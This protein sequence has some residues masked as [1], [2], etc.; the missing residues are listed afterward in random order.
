VAIR[1]ITPPQEK[2]LNEIRLKLL[3]LYAILAAAE[4]EESKGLFFSMLHWNFT[5]LREIEKER[6]VLN[7]EERLEYDKKKIEDSLPS[8]I[9]GIVRLMYLHYDEYM[10]KPGLKRSTLNIVMFYEDSR[11]EKVAEDEEG[12]MK[13][14]KTLPMVKKKTIQALANEYIVALIAEGRTIIKEHKLRGEDVYKQYARN[15]GKR[16]FSALRY[17]R[18]IAWL[19]QDYDPVI[20]PLETFNFANSY[21]NWSNVIG[22][23]RHQLEEDERDAQ[24]INSDNFQ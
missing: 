20:Q 24:N 1:V 18:F 16:Y 21:G 5:R 12:I 7:A 6:E 19:T 17:R 3:A 11:E 13:K 2:Q 9:D 4:K 22:N 8:L 15:F 10:E 14:I 23:I